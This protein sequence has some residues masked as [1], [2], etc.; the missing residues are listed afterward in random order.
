MSNTHALPIYLQIAELL[1][2]EIAAGHLLDGERLPPERDMAERLGIS[3]GT[4][5]SRIA[6][7]RESLR[8]KLGE[9]FK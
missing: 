4:V 1:A 2:R 6:R 3:V 8:S 5:K 9:D 7:A